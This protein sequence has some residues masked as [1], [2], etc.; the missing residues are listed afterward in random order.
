MLKQ[1][2]NNVGR[3]TEGGGARI[4]LLYSH[5]HSRISISDIS[6]LRYDQTQT[7]YQDSRSEWMM[8]VLCDL[9]FEEGG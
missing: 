9:A 7:Y 5:L 3:G 2:H 6:P 4:A 8:Y 1:R